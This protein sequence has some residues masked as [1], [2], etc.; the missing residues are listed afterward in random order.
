MG[1]DQEHL[2]RSD[3][4]AEIVSISHELALKPNTVLWERVSDLCRTKLATEKDNRKLEALSAISIWDDQQYR[5]YLRRGH[6]R[7]L[8]CLDLICE[9][10]A[11]VDP[12]IGALEDKIADYRRRIWGT[13][14][15][16]PQL[17][18]LLP[19]HGHAGGP[20]L[21]LQLPSPGQGDAEAFYNASH[22]GL[23]EIV[24]DLDILRELK[25]RQGQ[26]IW[27]K[28]QVSLAGPSTIT[29]LFIHGKAGSGKSI[30]LNRLAVRLLG[31]KITVLRC[32]P[33]FCRF[34]KFCD[35]LIACSAERRR[36]SGRYF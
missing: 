12:K 18:R 21:K 5:K 1:A 15:E 16:T 14:E 19:R 17:P 30:A 6:S 26:P 8:E 9:V 4:F 7:Y 27:E 36:A 22:T 34:D 3:R 20:F 13:S 32:D 2:A 28:L 25:N 31:N 33:P 23:G 29:R 24:D 35:Y 11:T 10:F